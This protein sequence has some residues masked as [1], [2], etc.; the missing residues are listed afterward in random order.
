MSQ[1]VPSSKKLLRALRFYALVA[2]WRSIF[3]PSD[4]RS[5]VLHRT[6]KW[7]LPHRRLHSD[8]PGSPGLFTGSLPARIGTVCAAMVSHARRCR[9]GNIH[10]ARSTNRTAAPSRCLVVPGRSQSCD[11][12]VAIGTPTA[13]PRGA[14]R[15]EGFA[16]VHP[17]RGFLGPGCSSR[18]RSV[19]AVVPG[20]ARDYRGPSLGWADVRAN[21]GNHGQFGGHMLAALRRR[22]GHAS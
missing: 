15:C 10:Q 18:D 13:K 19:V 6:L 5:N 4:S 14:C 1:N 9:S 3:L 20:T 21:C 7:H 16:L 2:T 22:P 11:Q 12:S 8:G 17:V